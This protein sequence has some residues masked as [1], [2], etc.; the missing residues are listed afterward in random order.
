MDGVELPIPPSVNG[1]WRA[2]R[3]AGKTRV[4]RSRAYT[5]WLEQAVLLLRFQLPKATAYPVRVTV[6]IH[7]GKGWR[8]NR[9]LDNAY[10]AVSDALVHAERLADDDGDHVAEVV[11]RFGATR[12]FAV[13]HVAVQPVE[14][15]A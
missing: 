13:A 3:R 14:V 1:L 10:K 9:D 7:R 8:S 5:S 15:A 6:T 4:I 12:K 2:L 11:M